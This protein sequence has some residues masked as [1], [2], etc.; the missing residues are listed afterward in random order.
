MN[1]IEL[2]H[3]DC[4]ELMNNIPDNSVD[5]FILDPPYFRILNERWDKFKNKY[6]YYN[7]SREYLKAVF[8]KHRLN[9]N[10]ILFGCSRNVNIM[11]HLNCFLED[12]GYEYIEE[13]IIDKGMKSVAGRTSPKIKMLPPVSENIFFYRKNA[14][15]Y[16]NKLLRKKFDESGLKSSDIKRELGIAQNGGGNWTK[17]AGKTEFPLFPT[18]EHWDKLANIFSIN[19]NYSD[20]EEVYNPIMGVTNVWNDIEF[21]NKNRIHPS[22]KPILLFDRII[23]LFSKSDDLITDPFMGGGNSGISS[24]K[25]GRRFIGIEKEKKYFDVAV[26]R[27][28]NA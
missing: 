23:N 3:G 13:I 11:S 2:W 27:I 9:G 12:I 20:I 5:L 15:P 28:G 18:R 8:E 26:E 25:L 1:N 6:E 10:L 7:W 14:K 19:I 16:I 21:Y 24:R 22:E 4:L 17:Y